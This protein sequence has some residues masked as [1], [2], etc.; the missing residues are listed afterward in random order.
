MIAL[1]PDTVA[2]LLQQCGHWDVAENVVT[3]LWSELTLPA[4]R[5]ADDRARKN[6][7]TLAEEIRGMP[8]NACIAA[9]GPRDGSKMALRRSG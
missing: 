1:L 9:R 7:A 5:R 6:Q 3:S 8:Q 2:E 4:L